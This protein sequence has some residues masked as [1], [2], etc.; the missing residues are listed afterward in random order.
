MGTGFTDLL[1]KEIA[2]L[3]AELSADPRFRKLQTLRE[4]LALYQQEASTRAPRSGERRMSSGTSKRTMSTARAHAL[5]LSADC[6]RAHGGGPVPTRD[7]YAWIEPLGAEIGGTQKVSNLSAM[8]S[9]SDR[10][11]SHGRAGWTL[12][13]DQSEAQPSS[14]DMGG[15]DEVTDA[16]GNDADSAEHEGSMLSQAA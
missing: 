9:Q 10:F 15:S 3:E 8:L 7:I 14:G 13:T 6:I 2:E 11:K 5:E 16:N 12:A 4:A 1:R